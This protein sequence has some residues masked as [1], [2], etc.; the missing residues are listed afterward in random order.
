MNLKDI[1]LHK[2]G[3]KRETTTWSNL[4]VQSKKVELIE[5]RGVTAWEFKF[6]I[7]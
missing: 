4:Y 7:R 1:M 5:V 3:T 6:S 2:P